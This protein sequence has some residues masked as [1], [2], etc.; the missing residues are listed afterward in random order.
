[1]RDK[2]L[3]DI[4][5]FHEKINIFKSVP[6]LL[7]PAVLLFVLLPLP[8]FHTVFGNKILYVRSLPLHSIILPTIAIIVRPYKKVVSSSSSS[9]RGY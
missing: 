4:S 8:Y 1:M 5:Q 7:L 6:L 2:G 9:F 3:A